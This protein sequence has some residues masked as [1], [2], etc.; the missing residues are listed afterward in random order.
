[1]ITRR[2]E[3]LRLEGLVTPEAV[4]RIEAAIADL[5]NIV[6][7]RTAAQHRGARHEVAR[8]YDELGISFPPPSAERLWALLRDRA[9]LALDAI[10]EEV[11]ASTDER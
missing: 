5:K 2:G 10:R 3:R 8:R 9:T 4:G 11:Q 7:I 6:R 1:V